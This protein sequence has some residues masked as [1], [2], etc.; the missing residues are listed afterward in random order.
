MA[1]NPL[2]RFICQYCGTQ[3]WYSPVHLHLLDPRIDH[4]RRDGRYC[5]AAM[6]G[7]KHGQL[8]IAAH[9]AAS[10]QRE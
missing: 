4:D 5:Q 7:H 8:L 2:C 3:G 9:D 1:R 6:R 10:R